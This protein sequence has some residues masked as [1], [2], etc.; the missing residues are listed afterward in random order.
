[1]AKKGG[2][3][4]NLK[5]FP[6]GTSGNQSGRPKDL[7]TKDKV[8]AIIGRFSYMNRDEL[9]AVVQDPKTPMI[10]IMVASVMV[11]AAKDGDYSRLEAI[12]ARSI[13]KVKETKELILPK[14][15]VVQRRDGSQTVLSAEL[16]D[17]EE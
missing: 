9:Q 16:A 10:E 13:G 7:L 3:P 14:P 11:K 8:D 15:T 17:S 12:L 2:N 4:K 1:M 6:K 5:P